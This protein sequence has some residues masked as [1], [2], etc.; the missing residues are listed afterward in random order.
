MSRRLSMVLLASFSASI[1][2][3]I[4]ASA[5]ISSTHHRSRNGM[6]GT[7]SYST[8]NYPSVHTSGGRLSSSFRFIRPRTVIAASLTEIN[9]NDCNQK[10]ITNSPTRCSSRDAAL[11]I[12]NSTSD[13]GLLIVTCDASGRGGGSKHDGISAILRIRHGANPTSTQQS[14]KEKED[15]IDVAARRTVPSR[16]SSEVAAIALGIKR[17][18]QYIPQP[19]RKRVLILSDS[20]YALDFFCGSGIERN[21]FNNIGTSSSLPIRRVVP[22]KRKKK[23]KGTSSTRG[24]KQITQSMEI[25]EE[26]HRR[27]L[28]SLMEETPDGILFAKV[29]SSSRGVGINTNNVGDDGE[30]NG[31]TDS[32]DGMGFIDHDAADHLSSITRS[33]ANSFE[34]RAKIDIPNEMDMS[35]LF[36]AVESLGREDIAWLEN[37]ESDKTTSINGNEH[38]Y[39]ESRSTNESNNFWKTIEVVGSDAREDRH[40]RKQRRTERIQEMLGPSLPTL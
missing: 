10:I 20:E 5:M 6:I 4:C 13:D 21:A 39:K 26:A 17:A 34:D 36:R 16:K 12:Q 1:L 3:F 27:L 9:G 14:T 33:V 8:P 32:W 24:K 22:N 7:N 30:L 35:S 40:R 2:N 15:F 25:R 11:I 28:V 19:R 31:N 37:S 29:R 23:R 18:L 38:E